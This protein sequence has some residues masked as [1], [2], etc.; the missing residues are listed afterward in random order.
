MGNLNGR[1]VQDPI[2]GRLISSAFIAETCVTASYAITGPGLAADWDTSLTNIPA[3]L[4]SA[5][6]QTVMDNALFAITAS[7]ASN[8]GG[9]ENAFSSSEQVDYDLIQNQPTL[10]DSASF[11]ITASYSA[12][13][14]T[15]AS[16]AISASHAVTASH[17]T[18]TFVS[19]SYAGLAAVAYTASYVDYTNVANKAELP[20]DLVSGSSQVD[21]DATT[22]FT[23]SEHF[24]QDD[25][26]AVGT[27]A[28]GDVSAILPVD[29]VSGSSQIDYD[30][31]QNQ[32]TLIESASYSETASHALNVVNPEYDDIQNKP[33]LVSGSSQIDHNSTTNYDSNKHFTQAGITTVGTV[34]VGD[35]SAIITGDTVLS[36]SYAISSSLAVTASYALNAEPIPDGT[37]SGS[38]QI[39]HND[40]TGYDSNRHFTQVGIVSLGTVTVGDV[41]QIITGDTVLTASYAVIAENVLGSIESASFATTASYA[42]NAAPIIYTPVSASYATTMSID[43]SLYEMTYAT[44]SANFH[45]SMSNPTLLKDSMVEVRYSAA[46]VTMSYDLNLVG[47]TQQ[48]GSDEVDYMLVTCTNAGGEY[49]LTILNG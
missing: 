7:Y 26:T 37:V 4:V 24:E 30:N 9:L 14:P 48:S 5:S 38:L 39:T 25:I 12:N 2:T 33:T 46:N 1:I 28:S 10:I 11:A 6:D 29:T 13:I 45:I 36:S 19:A 41:S 47:G 42:N 21:H 16:Y 44:A 27:V 15:T 31:I 22:N 20:A 17:L 49:I 18:G 43:N 23:A 34:N 8:A 40:T 32:P 35:V 3:G